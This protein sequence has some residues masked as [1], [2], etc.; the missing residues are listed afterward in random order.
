MLSTTRFVDKRQLFA[1]TGDDVP[2]E[3]WRLD[4]EG[5]GIDCTAT[6]GPGAGL[7]ASGPMDFT[8]SRKS[9]DS[10]LT[11][12]TRLDGTITDPQGGRWRADVHYI[13]KLVNGNFDVKG[14][15]RLVPLG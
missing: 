10:L 15:G 7:F 1:F 9:S 6:D 12:D 2:V 4:D 5:G 3:A 14:G 13:V 11:G 8:D